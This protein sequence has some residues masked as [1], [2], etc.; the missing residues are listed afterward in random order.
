MATVKKK[1][2]TAPQPRKRHYHQGKFV[3]RNPGK[4]TGDPTDIVYRSRWELLVMQRFDLN[5]KILKWGSETVVIPYFW[6]GDGKPHRYYT[7]FVIAAQSN[8]GSIVKMIIEVKPYAQTIEPKKTRGK[9]K[10]TLEE[11]CKTYSKNQAKWAAAREYC[12]K[13]GFIFWVMTEKDIFPNGKA[14]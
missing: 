7:D 8:D 3:P 5:P 10:T 4:Y 14:W 11:E 2:N 1:L 6:E 9:K 13:H 12:K